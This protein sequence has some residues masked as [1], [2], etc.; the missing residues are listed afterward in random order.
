MRRKLAAFS[1]AV[2]LTLTG[3][4]ASGDAEPAR[5]VTVTETVTVTATASGSTSVPATNSSAT[6][7]LGE[8]GTGAAASKIT[9]YAY[10][11]AVT[12]PAGQVPDSPDT[13]WVGIDV[14]VCVQAATAVGRNLWSISDASNGSYGQLSESER[15]NLKS[16]IYP[17]SATPVQAGQCTRGWITYTVPLD[18]RIVVVRYSRPADPSSSAL[19]LSWT[20]A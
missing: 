9:V 3:C 12:S 5:T 19:L 18:A 14:E 16:P 11:D 1:V 8:S 2:A 7:A 10:D 6:M 4:G 17:M 13:R 20:V 15:F